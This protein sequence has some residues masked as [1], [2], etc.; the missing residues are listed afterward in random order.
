MHVLRSIPYN[1][2]LSRL[3]V[4]QLVSRG[5]PLVAMCHEAALHITAKQNVFPDADGDRGR[6]GHLPEIGL[7]P[8]L[9]AVARGAGAEEHLGAP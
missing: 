5:P 1:S 2:N 6:A 4:C 9:L 8:E 3:N 7:R